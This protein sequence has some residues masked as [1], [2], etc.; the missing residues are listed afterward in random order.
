MA[1]HKMVTV[2]GVRYRAEDL[3]RHQ[4]APQPTHKESAPKVAKKAPAKKAAGSTL[5]T[6]KVS[7]SS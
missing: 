1:E 4:A 3:P 5:S 2:D 6:E 7:K